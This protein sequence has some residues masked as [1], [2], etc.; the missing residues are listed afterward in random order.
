VLFLTLQIQ[1]PEQ[2]RRKLGPYLYHTP[3]GT[4]TQL[5]QDGNGTVDSLHY[6]HKGFNEVLMMPRGTDKQMNEATKILVG[7]VVEKEKYDPGNPHSN[8]KK[9][10]WPTNEKIKQCKENQ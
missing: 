1:L 8:G 9:P 5:H 2:C 6:C 7:D 10:P 3:P 4:F